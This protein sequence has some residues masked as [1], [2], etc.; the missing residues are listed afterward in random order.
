MP[1]RHLEVHDKEPTTT[2]DAPDE[3]DHESKRQK[4]ERNDGTPCEKID[5][6]NNRTGIGDGGVSIPRHDNSLLLPDLPIETVDDVVPY[7]DGGLRKI[8]PYRVSYVW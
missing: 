4:E 7:I 3:E 8:P 1:K 5:V 2:S 6:S